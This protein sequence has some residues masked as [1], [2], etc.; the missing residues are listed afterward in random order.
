MRKG[1]LIATSVSLGAVVLASF[2]G[3]FRVVTLFYDFPAANG[4]LPAAVAE[5]QKNGMP[6]VAADLFPE[7]VADDDNAAPAI[8]A[9]IE[10]MPSQKTDGTLA[11][12][13]KKRNFSAVDAQYGP[14]LSLVKGALDR[15]KVDFKRDWDLGPYILMPEYRSMKSM[16]RAA[17]ARAGRNAAKGHDEEALADL[18]LARQ[19][20]LWAG[21]EPTMIS[22]LVRISSESIALGGLERCLDAAANDP[23]RIA[24]YSAW[25]SQSPPLPEFGRAL[26]G[27][28]F[29]GLV[30]TRNLDVFGGM[31]NLSFAEDENKERKID[32]ARL[33]RSGLP[34][35][36]KLRGFLAR[37]LQVWNEAYR[38]TDGFRKSPHEIGRQMAAIDYRLEDEK[39]L[40]YVL[41]RILMPLFSQAGDSITQL[42]ARRAVQAGLAEALTV[43]GQTGRWPTKVSPLDPFTGKPLKVKIK[44][45]EF[46]VYSIGRDGKD[47]GGLLRGEKGAMGKIVDEVA[48]FPP[49]R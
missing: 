35:E 46:R 40:S 28:A 39:G 47:N 6:F 2:Y 13:L 29:M 32:P 27:E 5:Y 30:T 38:R 9:A 4:E 7:K 14:S 11:Q 49:I 31:K 41:Q 48:V 26:R 19:I 12:E 20:S 25:L 42:D 22:M 16:A 43:R 17:A 33:R 44:G 1:C 21:Q 10:V 23:K 36:S 18:T 24:K 45:A 15:P 34:E 3:I 8:R 37:H